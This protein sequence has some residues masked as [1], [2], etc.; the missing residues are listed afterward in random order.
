MNN[1]FLILQG[2]V[3]DTLQHADK[4]RQ[5]L[6]RTRSFGGVRALNFFPTLLCCLL[7]IFCRSLEEEGTQRPKFL[8][9]RHAVLH[10]RR[11]SHH[12]LHR[13]IRTMFFHD[14]EEQ[15]GNLL[16]RLLENILMIKPYTFVVGELRASL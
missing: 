1:L 14:G 5:Y 12:A 9:E 10:H 13:L 16:D 8:D 6:R 15:R 7:V 3:I 4:F 2:E 11:N